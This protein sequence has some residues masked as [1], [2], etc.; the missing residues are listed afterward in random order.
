[1]STFDEALNKTLQFEGG[2]VDNPADRGGRTNR[3]ITQRT[4]DAFRVSIMKDKQPVD[5]IDDDEVASIYR[6]NYWVACNCDALPADIACAVFDMAVNSG[7]WNA[8]LTLQ[9]ALGVKSDG[10]VGPTTL[11]AARQTPDALLRFLKG[12]GAF[13]KEVISVSPSQVAFLSGWISRLLDQ[14]YRP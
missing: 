5:F 13:I 4:Y 2:L 7:P 10:V 6:D 11:I 12:R 8:K 3:G 14:A 1:M 9:K